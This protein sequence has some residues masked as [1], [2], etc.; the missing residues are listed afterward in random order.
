MFL[1]VFLVPTVQGTGA[2]RDAIICLVL[3]SCVFESSDGMIT[4]RKKINKS[5]VSG[6]LGIETRDIL[7][8]LL[9]QPDSQR[10]L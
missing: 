1:V 7:P 8:W 2:A 10:S 6:H 9:S 4:Q 3:T 5:S